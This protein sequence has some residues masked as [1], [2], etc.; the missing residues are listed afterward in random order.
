MREFINE[1]NQIYQDSELN[2]HTN[3]KLLRQK[4]GVTQKQVAEVLHIDVTTLSHYET[5]IRVPDIETLIRLADYY[6]TSV[7]CIISCEAI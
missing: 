4:C 6:G 7:N 3:L 2:I 1:S 5:G